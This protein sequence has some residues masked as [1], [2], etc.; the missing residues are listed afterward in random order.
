MSPFLKATIPQAE[1]ERTIREHMAAWRRGNPEARELTPALDPAAAEAQMRYELAR[2]YAE[3]TVWRNDRYQ[4]SV[5]PVP[6]SGFPAMLHL[7]IKRIDRSPMHDWRELQEIK[8]ALVGPEHEAVELYPAESRKVD[9]ANQYHLWVIAEKGVQFPFGYD[10][11]I[12]QNST[13]GR[14]KQRPL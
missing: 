10:R 13:Y 5:R 1:T 3:E 9:T 7:S 14:A 2:L 6:E 4:V 11:R 8:N 12:V